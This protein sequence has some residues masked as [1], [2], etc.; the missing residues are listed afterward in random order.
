M[1]PADLPPDADFAASTNTSTNLSTD[2][3][4]Q[5]YHNRLYPWLLI[6]QLPQMQRMIVARFRKRNDAEAHLK[7]LR[8]LTPET[9]YQIVFDPVDDCGLQS[10][11]QTAAKS[12]ATVDSSIKT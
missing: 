3:R 2:P 11:F 5:T 12:K 1:I 9:V 4:A 8:Q 6:C 7:T 10:T